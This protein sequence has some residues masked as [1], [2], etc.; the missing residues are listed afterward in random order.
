VFLTHEAT[1]LVYRD[2]IVPALQPDGRPILPE[3]KPA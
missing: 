2:S 1:G 3:F